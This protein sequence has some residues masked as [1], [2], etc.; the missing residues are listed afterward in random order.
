MYHHFF[1]IP[2]FGQIA[3]EWGLLPKADG[4]DLNVPFDKTNVTANDL[5]I[6]VGLPI[7]LST[8]EINGEKEP[9]FLL[10]N[11]LSFGYKIP[12]VNIWPEYTKDNDGNYDLNL[13]N[14]DDHLI[15]SGYTVMLLKSFS[16]KW[17]VLGIG[18]FTY[19]EINPDDIK[20]ESMGI[21]G[22]LATMYT[23]KSKWS[24]DIGAIYS[25]V[26]GVVIQF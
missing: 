5:K 6:G 14:T 12:K 20:T 21:I 22:G 16:T 2:A 19:A 25:R 3:L 7:V 9:S 13:E 15:S 17:S 10:I 1:L 26:T 11:C 4:D 24:L 23:W 8:T 18:G